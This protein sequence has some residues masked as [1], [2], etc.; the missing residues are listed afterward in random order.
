MFEDR[1]VEHPGRVVLTPVSGETNTYD[2]TRAE[3]NVTEEGT[4]L[5]AENMNAQIRDM[6]ED[7][8]SKYDSAFSIDENGNVGFRNLQ[9]GKATLKMKTANTTVKLNV[10]Y[11]QEFTK[12]PNVVV[13]P[14]TKVPGNVS[15]GVYDITTT[16]FTIYMYRTNKADTIVNWMA[17]I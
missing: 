8:L 9:S 12:A 3:G 1:V 14:R 5:N 2:M 6:I 4:P 10:K 16:G 11:P 17:F 7:A 13:T 15:V